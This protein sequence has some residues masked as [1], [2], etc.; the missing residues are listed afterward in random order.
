[1]MALEGVLCAEDYTQPAI[2][3]VFTLAGGMQV[4]QEGYTGTNTSGFIIDF[5]YDERLLTESPPFYPEYSVSG[6]Q[7]S[8]PATMKPNLTAAPNPF[9]SS[10]EI[11]LPYPGTIRIYDQSG[12]LTAESEICDSWVFDS[13]SFPAGIYVASVTSVSRE[14]NSIR[15]V[16]I[17]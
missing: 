7:H 4:C 10:V 3:A 6:I 9:S 15:L 8:F 11:V 5:S 2:Q 17:D 16:K 13:S 12:R 1:M 14:T